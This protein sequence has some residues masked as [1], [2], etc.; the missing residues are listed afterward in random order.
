MQTVKPDCVVCELWRVAETT[1][2]C[3]KEDCGN[4]GIDMNGKLAFCHCRN[5]KHLPSRI[6]R[7]EKCFQS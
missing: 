1:L 4:C 3:S 2:L 7:G 6:E 5:C